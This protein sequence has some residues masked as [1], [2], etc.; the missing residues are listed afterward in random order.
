[1]LINSALQSYVKSLFT[2]RSLLPH[3]AAANYLYKEDGVYKLK[4]ETKWNY[5]IQ[6]EMALSGV[7]NAD[8]VIY[9]N[10]GIMV[11]DVPF[12]EELWKEMPM[13]LNKFYF[14]F[15]IPELL[16]QHIKKQG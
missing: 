11:I 7:K 5:Q 2:K 4:R 1:M 6:G 9:T 14:I 3:V 10:E 13:K 8:P 12:D 15:M 16:S